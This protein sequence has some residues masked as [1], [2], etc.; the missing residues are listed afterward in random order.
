M[1]NITLLFGY[2]NCTCEPSMLIRG[3]GTQGKSD[4]ASWLGCFCYCFSLSL[5]DVSQK[6]RQGIVG[7]TMT[8]VVLEEDKIA[9]EKDERRKGRVFPSPYNTAGLG[10]TNK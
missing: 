4:P 8:S 9:R 7:K 2:F 3:D 1:A 5:Q 10:K 6:I